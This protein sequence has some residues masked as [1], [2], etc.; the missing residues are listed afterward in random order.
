MGGEPNGGACRVL[1]HLSLFSGIGGIDLAAEWAGFS[2]VG[3]CEIDAFNQAVLRKHWP[4]VPIWG[5]VRGITVESLRL[6][7]VEHVHLLTGGYPCQPFSQTGKQRGDE[8]DRY[9]WPEMRRLVATLRPLWVVGENVL[10]H[11]HVGL[12]EVLADLDGLGYASQAFVIPACAVGA[13]HRRD[14]V[15]VV[16]NAIGDRHEASRSGGNCGHEAIS[17]RGVRQGY[18]QAAAVTGGGPLGRRG[19]STRATES[20]LGG[21]TD[22]LSAWLDE[23]RWPAYPGEQQ[24]DWEPARLKDAA[25]PYRIERLR[26][27]GNAVNPRQVYPLLKAIAQAC[28]VST[29]YQEGA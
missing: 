23:H 27:L 3:F 8:D 1:T 13:P 5:D 9:L 22:G 25:Q 12:D 15:F 4:N 17:G 14:R 11:I 21:S 24:H 20:G 2:T 29:D 10:N 28:T 19:A 6:A 16:A 26:S 18:I 7:G